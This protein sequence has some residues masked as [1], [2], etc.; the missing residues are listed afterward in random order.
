MDGTKASES[1]HST[2]INY[3]EQENECTETEEKGSLLPSQLNEER[4]GLDIKGDL[5][6]ETGEVNKELIRNHS[7]KS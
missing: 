2:T 3:A 7:V 6:S 4:M 5:S 1:V